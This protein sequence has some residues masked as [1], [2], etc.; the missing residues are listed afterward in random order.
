M[1]DPSARPTLAD[2]FAGRIADKWSASVPGNWHH[3]EPFTDD[4]DCVKGDD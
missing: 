3:N 1:A 4:D 2:I